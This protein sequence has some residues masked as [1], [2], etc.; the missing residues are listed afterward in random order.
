MLRPRPN[1]LHL[2]A[3][4][5]ICM[6]SCDNTDGPG[7][8]STSGGAGAKTT[9]GG[10]AG[11]TTTSGGG[12]VNAGGANSG[13][14]GGGTSNTGGNTTGGAT[15]GTS[16]TGGNATGGA[17]GAGGNATGGAGGSTGGTG[18]A[19]GTSDAGSTGGGSGDAGLPPL[20]P[21][22]DPSVS[23]LKVWETQVVSGT[24]VPASG[25]PLRDAGKD[26]EMYIEWTLQGSSSYGT[27]NAPLNNQGEYTNGADPAKNA[28]DISGATGVTLEYAATGST[29]MQIRT[30]TVPHGGDHFRADLP[31]TGTEIKTITLPFAD[32]RR[33]GGQTP[34]GADILKD[35]FSF[36]F[37][38]AATTKV[39]LRQVRVAGFTPPCN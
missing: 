5:A 31:I 22:T 23:R 28:V 9:S 11:A 14:A 10:A 16:N 2:L 27:A 19:S 25:S 6:A 1:L 21:C 29:Y 20:T 17:S 36:T 26:Y 24:Q 39:T 32:F 37:V 38:G 34:P 30:G 3:L 18:G 8:S 7:E 12:T 4:A 35:V 33:P 13:G 15:G